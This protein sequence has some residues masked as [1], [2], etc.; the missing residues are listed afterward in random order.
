MNQMSKVPASDSN[1][2]GSTV[3]PSR[4]HTHLGSKLDLSAGSE[5]I[6]LNDEIHQNVLSL[7][8]P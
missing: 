5:D 8:A 6:I 3:E 1:A 2:I 7:S 4:L